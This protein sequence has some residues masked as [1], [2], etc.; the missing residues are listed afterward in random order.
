MKKLI[1][2]LIGICLFPMHFTGQEKKQNATPKKLETK[3]IKEF[4][5]KGKYKKIINDTLFTLTETEL[6]YILRVKPVGQNFQKISYYYKKTLI[7]K[8]ENLRFKSM[9]IGV[10]KRYDKTGNLIKKKNY[11]KG[12]ENFTVNDLILFVNKKLKIDLNKDREGL[13][14][15]R[16]PQGLSNIN[17]PEYYIDIYNKTSNKVRTIII[18]GN[19]RSIISDTSE[20]IRASI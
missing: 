2:I 8:S 3:I 15:I 1:I 11:D 13:S 12:F 18:N 10:E 5:A 9:D 7:L 17:R 20:D 4:K 19:T 6:D 14:V 16:F